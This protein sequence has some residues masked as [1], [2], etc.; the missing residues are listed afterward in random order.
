MQIIYSILVAL[1]L[2]AAVGVYLWLR[3]VGQRA[4]ENSEAETARR[5]LL[6]ERARAWVLGALPAIITKVENEWFRPGIKTGPLKLAAVKAELLKIVPTELI[7]AIS[8]AALDGMIKISLD[9]VLRLWNE[10]PGVLV[11]NQVAG[12][13]ADVVAEA[14]GALTDTICEAVAKT[15]TKEPAAKK[16]LAKPR[17]KPTGTAKSKATGNEG[18]G[19][20]EP[21]AST[22]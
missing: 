7:A 16:A 17:K 21:T 22:E 20:E 9:D 13:L 19:G 10:M 6:I 8:E 2:V 4:A 1:V 15:L 14:P 12:G 3:L 11:E 5:A 18:V